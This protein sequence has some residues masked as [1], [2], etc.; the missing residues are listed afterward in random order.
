MTIFLIKF[1][2]FVKKYWQVLLLI[3]GV[4]IS[5]IV[6][7]KADDSFIDKLKKIQDAHDKEIKKIEE[8]R[9]QEK[10]EHE[11]NLKKLQDTLGVIQKQY[12]NA[13]KDLDASKKKE[14]EN[15]VK[16]Y[17]ND[18]NALAK[19]LSDATGFAVVLPE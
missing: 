17:Q 5:V 1:W 19:R 2:A 12:D 14:I 9:V 8:A 3:L 4:V 16:K 11:A 18:P 13:K 15:I 6:F 7:K 10:R